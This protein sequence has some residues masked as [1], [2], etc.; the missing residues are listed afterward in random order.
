MKT[1]DTSVV[2]VGG[3]GKPVEE[4]GVDDDEEQLGVVEIVCDAIDHEVKSRSAAV[5]AIGD[6]YMASATTQLQL[7]MSKFPEHIRK[8]PMK[9]FVKQHCPN[10]KVRARS[11][12]TVFFDIVQDPVFQPLGGGIL[13]VSSGSASVQNMPSFEASQ[14]SMAHH[15][16]P[17]Y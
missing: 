6:G 2:V 1:K 13:D 16:L 3:G 12:G 7:L 11:E 8:M 15:V 10:T 9:K 17:C 14:T 4:A 5:M